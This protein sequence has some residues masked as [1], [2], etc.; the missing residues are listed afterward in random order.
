MRIDNSGGGQV[1][2]PEPA[3]WGL[4]PHELIHLSYGKSTLYRV[5]KEEVDGTPQ[6]GVVRIPVK[7]KS[8]AMRARFHQDGSMYVLGYRGWQTN[9]ATP[10]AFH[11][12]RYNNKPVTIPDQLKATD[13]GLY[14]R[15]EKE[16]DASSVADKFNF[17]VE[18]WKYMR[19]KQYG[20]GEFS[21]DNPDLEL[22]KRAHEQETKRHKKHDQVE[23]ARSTLLPDKKPSSCTSPA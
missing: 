3:K 17:K 2:T 4:R 20:S 19:T 18:R 6:G 9:A 7:L 5:L 13:K 14:I 10:Q 8:S 11:R 22:E 21:I 16:L 1:W 23:I 15:F 12:I